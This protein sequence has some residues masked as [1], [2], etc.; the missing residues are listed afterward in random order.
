MKCINPIQAPGKQSQYTT[1]SSPTHC[2]FIKL[3]KN[4]IRKKST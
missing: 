1:T 4:E 2:Y 3:Q